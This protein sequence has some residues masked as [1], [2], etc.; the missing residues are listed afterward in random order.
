[1]FICYASDFIEMIE[2]FPMRTSTLSYSSCTFVLI[3]LVMTANLH[4]LNNL[5]FAMY[6]P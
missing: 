5:T 1:M 4:Q 3:K 6:Q 2:V